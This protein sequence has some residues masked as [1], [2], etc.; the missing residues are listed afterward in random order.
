MKTLSHFFKKK[1]KHLSGIL[2]GDV[3]DEVKDT[4]RVSPLVVVPRDE[5]DK[6]VVQGDTSL[7]I[8]NGGVVVSVQVGRDNL[9]LSV[10]ENA[11]E[12]SLRGSLDGSLDFLVGGWL[13]Q[14]DGQVD[15]GDVLGW[16]TESHT[17]ELAVELWDN[18]SDSLSGTGG[19]WDDV[20]G[21]GT[22]SSPVLVGWTVDG[23]LGGSERVDGGHET[24][25]N[26]EVIVDDL[27]QWG[28]A[29]GG[30]RSVGEDVDVWGVLV[31]VDTNDEH[32]S[33]S[34]RSG[35]DAGQVR[36]EHRQWTMFTYT[37]LAPPFK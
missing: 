7:S 24:L 1:A 3:A 21:S 37:F 11:L 18:L 22:S 26:T 34:G 32:W 10:A 29:V 23:L 6:V 19:G 14:A 5:L 12:L 9:I 13:L 2:L 16:D 20:G 27:G 25:N 4:A 17:G 35:D 36:L 31:L 33:V 15:N 30:A 28:K 8:E